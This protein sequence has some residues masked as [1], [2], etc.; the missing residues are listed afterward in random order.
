MPTIKEDIATAS[1]WAAAALRSS[2]YNIDYSTESLQ[3]IDRCYDEQSVNGV[4]RPNGLFST[5]LD[6]RIFAVGCYVG[7]VIRRARGGEWHGDDADPHA[8]LHVELRLKDGTLC[9]PTQR[10]LNRLRNG[11]QDGIVA[12]AQGLGVPIGASSKPAGKGIFRR[13]FGK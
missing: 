13:L 12:Y 9:W 3:E 10:A 1:E 8:R 5:D 7:E 2:G 11:R 4:P 6:S